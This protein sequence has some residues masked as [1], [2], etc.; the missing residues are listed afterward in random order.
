MIKVD[1]TK[2]TGYYD[3]Q[4]QINL[5]LKK[6]DGHMTNIDEI[7]TTGVW[8]GKSHDVCYEVYKAVFDNLKEY[9]ESYSDFGLAINNLVC[10]VDIFADKSQAVGKVRE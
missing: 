1:E 4:S 3:A 8:E 9:S 7:L 5:N 6:L 10:N 2:L